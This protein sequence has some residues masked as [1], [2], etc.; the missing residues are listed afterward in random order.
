MARSG[1]FAGLRRRRP[2]LGLIFAY[3]LLLNALSAAVF[4]IQAV[5]AALDPLS[6]AV[7]CDSSGSRTGSDPAQHNNRHQP[8]CTLC[9]SACPMGGVVLGLGGTGATEVALRTAVI[10][11]G[12][13]KPV[14]SVHP[15]SVHFSDRQSQAPPAIG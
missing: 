9:G 3:A 7:T 14:S 12:S 4:D 10:L 13:A 11:D 15:R 1:F 8:D 2:A 5:A 6:S